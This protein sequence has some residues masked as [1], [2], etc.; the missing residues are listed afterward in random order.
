MIKTLN[1]VTDTVSFD[2]SNTLILFDNVEYEEYPFHW[3]TPVEVIMPTENEYQVEVSSGETYTLREGDIMFIRPGSLHRILA[4]KGRRIIFQFSMNV[5]NSLDDFDEFFPSGIQEIII[6]PETHPTIHEDCQ[7]LML[8]I[9]EEYLSAA[10]LKDAAVYSKLLN[11]LVLIDRNST[12]FNEAFANSTDNK[13]KE[14]IDKFVKITEYI[15]QHC[16][17]DITLDEI[18]EISGFSKFH[19]SRLFRQYTGTSYYKYVNQKRI[20]YAE[21]LLIDPEISITEA[22]VQCGFNSISSFIRMFKQLKHCTPT[23]FRG[24]HRGR[25]N[26]PPS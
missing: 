22:A 17:E 7:R 2:L 24:M 6:T 4:A 25:R 13:Q 14:Y 23:E 16:N 1:S 9:K 15:K 8:E 18:A 5:L 12:I 26:N 3:H 19:F 10:P 20:D 21:Q 11:I